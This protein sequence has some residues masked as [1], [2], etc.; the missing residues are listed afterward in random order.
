MYSGC[1]ISR[2]ILETHGL[3]LLF[4]KSDVA[5]ALHMS[6]WT[7]KGVWWIFLLNVTGSLWYRFIVSLMFWLIE[8]YFFH[9]SCFKLSNS[10]TRWILHLVTRILIKSILVTKSNLVNKIIA[11][12]KDEYERSVSS[13]IQHNQLTGQNINSINVPLFANTATLQI[14]T[15]V[16]DLLYRS[17]ES[18]YFK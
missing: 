6:M 11:H 13:Y 5:N 16:Y 14:K 3:L 8:M 1:K 17:L 15:V 2:E 4:L 10:E 9:H 12:L 18:E 7:L